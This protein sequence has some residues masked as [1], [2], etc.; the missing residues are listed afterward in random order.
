MNIVR[1]GQ[2]W[3]DR[4]THTPVTVLFVNDVVVDVID[5]A[6]QDDRDGTGWSRQRLPRATF[7]HEYELDVNG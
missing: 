6:E 1:P 4:V 3:R 5:H 2:C 7:I